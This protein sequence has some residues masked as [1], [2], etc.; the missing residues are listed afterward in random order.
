MNR[1]SW[2]LRSDFQDYWSR[3]VPDTGEPATVQGEI[4]WATLDLSGMYGNSGGGNWRE[5]P[6]YYEALA[7]RVIAV[8]C[9]G[10]LGEDE[11]GFVQRVVTELRLY[12]RGVDRQ[13]REPDCADV[14]RL[15]NLALEWCKRHPLLVPRSPTR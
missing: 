4:L 11:A 14:D 5:R 10:T 12:C 2:P 7:D 9:D 15:P 3:L 6:D 8:L 13:A 1:D